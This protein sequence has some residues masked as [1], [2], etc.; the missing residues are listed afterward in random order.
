MNDGKTHILVTG[1]LGFIGSHCVVKLINKN[2][3]VIVCDNLSNSDI[4]VVDKINKITQKSN[5]TFIQADIR[6]HLA[7]DKIFKSYQIYCVM[8]FAALKSVNESMKFPELYQSVNVD[9]TKNLLNVMKNNNCTK[10]IYSSSATVYGNSPSPCTENSVVGKG[11]TCNYAFNKYD[12]EQFLINNASLKS[13][14]IVI[15]RYFN[16][17][18]AHPSGIIGENPTGIPNNIFPYLLRVAAKVNDTKSVTGD[19]NPYDVF[20]VFGN[21]YNTHDGTCIRDYIHVQDLAQGHVEVMENIKNMGLGLYPL[22]GPER[23]KIY[24]LGTGT[25]TTV[26]QLI[27][28]MNHVLI[29]KNLNPI[30]FIIGPRRPGDL[31]ECYANVDKIYTELGF[32][33]THNIWDMCIDGLNF[34]NL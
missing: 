16:P 23:L 34:V 29:S 30:P 13:W 32:K 1:G 27:D 24:N 19:N 14:D 3:H 5:M 7:L 10:F 17:I 25:G 28:T 4:S 6:D 9:G 20:T 2:Y 26:M 31:D 8:H 11:L 33:T 15:L 18:G 21:N 12:I 22:G